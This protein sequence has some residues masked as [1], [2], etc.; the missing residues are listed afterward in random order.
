MEPV[1]P[2]KNKQSRQG[3]KGVGL[4]QL[5]QKKY[6]ML[7]NVPPEITKAFGELTEQILMFVHGPSGHGKSRL[8]MQFLKILM[9]FGDIDYVSPEE[10]HRHT[11]QK[12]A[13][14]NLTMEEHGGRIM[15]WDHEMTFDELVKKKQKKKSAKYTVIDSLQYWNIN[16][17]QYKFLKEHFPNKGFLFVSHSEGKSPKGRLAKDIEYDV[18]IKVRVE[19]YVAFVRAR[20]KGLQYY[21]IWED[22]AVRYWGRKMVNKYKK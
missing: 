18:D 1:K 19:G 20:G 2:V 13:M 8:M 10:G 11:M 14:E 15:F 5:F 7:E 12:S 21:I 3:P 9:P 6:R 22:G 17:S 16:M 4:K